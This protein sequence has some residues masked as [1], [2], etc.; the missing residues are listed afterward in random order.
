MHRKDLQAC[1]GAIA[2]AAVLVWTHSAIGQQSFKSGT[3]VVTVPVT[4][5]NRSGTER[6]RDLT[7]EDFRLFEDGKPQSISVF[8]RERRPISLCI[9][10][11]SSFSMKGRQQELAATAVSRIIEGLE[12][13]DEVSLVVFAGRSEVQVPW[14]NVRRFPR[15]NWAEWKTLPNSAVLDGV[16]TALD[17][18]DAAGN[19]R[20]ALLIVSDGAENS[21]QS[22]LEE[23][24]RTR[25][26]SETLIYAY[27]TFD[28]SASPTHPLAPRP[29][30]QGQSPRFQ[31]DIVRQ[32]T[33]VMEELAR[34]SGGWMWSIPSVDAANQASTA[35]IDELR[36]QYLLGYTPVKAF[37]DKRRKLKIE[38]TNRNFRV[39]H[40]DGY[41]A[42]R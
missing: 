21:S 39:R 34:D 14:T 9:A 10:L 36:Y 23:I 4:V 11:D 27:R 13:D 20:S 15:I 31:T 41:L 37:D 22:T 1:R 3:D 25:R 12:P 2:A 17:N 29:T 18:M 42:E 7:A 24:T 30:A 38:T 28:L 8:S 5:T 40:R 33:D 16:R 26:Q 6:I 35:L 19:P 32:P